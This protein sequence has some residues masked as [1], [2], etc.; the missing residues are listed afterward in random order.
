MAISENRFGL[1]KPAQLFQ[2][3]IN[4]E[5]NIN[6]IIFTP[7]ELF[8]CI[9]R[10]IGYYNQCCTYGW[11]GGETRLKRRPLMTSSYSAN[12]GKT[13]FSGLG[14][15]YAGHPRIRSWDCGRTDIKENTKGYSWSTTLKTLK[16]GKTKLA[17]QKL[18]DSMLYRAPP[19][20]LQLLL[21]APLK[22]RHFYITV[23]IENPFDESRVLTHY[24]CYWGPFWKQGSCCCCL[25]ESRVLTHYSCW[26]GSFEIR[27]PAH[28]ICCWW[29]VWKQN[30][31]ILLLLLGALWKQITYLW[32]V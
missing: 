20:V 16:V 18:S 7:L 23:E 19:L 2:C 25:F 10:K 21:V 17:T 1:S 29:S 6:C 32:F 12:R 13:F 24:G 31:C 22:A 14:R 27:V 28:C 8:S 15:R 5:Q 3:W 11:E 30:N 4:I 26:W 9:F